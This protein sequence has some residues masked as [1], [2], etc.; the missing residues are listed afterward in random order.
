MKIEKPVQI[1]VDEWWFKGC[2][3]QKQNHPKLKLYYVFKDTEDQESIDSCYNFIEAKKLCNLY[4]V[5]NFK[6]GCETFISC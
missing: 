6:Q 2:F 4:Q 3:I 1:E 5:K